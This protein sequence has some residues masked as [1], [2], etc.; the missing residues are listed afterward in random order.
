MFNTCVY[1]RLLPGRLFIGIFAGSFPLGRLRLFF[2]RIDAHLAV[3]S[4]R[5]RCISD[6]I[7]WVRM[8]RT[9]A[10]QVP[11][12]EIPSTIKD[13]QLLTRVDH[14]CGFEYQNPNPTSLLGNKFQ[15]RFTVRVYKQVQLPSRC[16]SIIKAASTS[17][18]EPGK[19]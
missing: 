12:S 1:F 9:A 19:V 13:C 11:R 8:G 2:F 17:A 18:P 15:I 7:L 10:S 16:E 3:I 5:V 4:Q 6:S 14:P